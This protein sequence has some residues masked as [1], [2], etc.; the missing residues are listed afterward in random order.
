MERMFNPFKKPPILFNQDRRLLEPANELAMRIK[1]MGG[2]ALLVGGFVRD[3]LTGMVSKD[4]DMEVYGV[5]AD[6]L[7]RTLH[8]LY[9]EK[10]D[11]VGR[12]FGVLKVFLGDGLD[13]DVSIP[14]RESKTGSGHKGF[15][16]TGDPNMSVKEAAR[17]RD[18]TMNSL[19]AD[20][21]TGQIVDSFGGMD[22]IKNKILRVTD[23]ERFQDDPLRVYRAVQFAARLGFT[24]EP[25]SF[26]LM[27]EMV[28]RG[29]LD[30]LSPERVTEELKKLLLKSERPSVGFEYMRE[31]G[32]IERDYPELHSLIG[33]EQ[34]P[35]WHPEGDVWIHTMM[36]LDQAATI[37][38]DFSPEERLQITVGALVHDLGKP[39]TTKRMEKHGVMRITSLGHEEA[40]VEPAKQLLGRFI[41]GDEVE[42][43]AVAAARDHLKPGM[44]HRAWEKGELNDEQYANALRKWLKRSL[45]ISWRVLLAA[46]ESDY[47]GRTLPGVQTE[48][49][50]AGEHAARVILERGLDKEA[51][52]PLVQGRDL[53]A[54]GLK[55]GPIFRRLIDKI[56][57]ARDEGRIT[58]REEA[59]DLAKELISEMK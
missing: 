45:P 12:S 16:V 34:E 23:P 47:R 35:E 9:P 46:S 50:A 8:Q 15:A 22:D 3:S 25:K 32:I 2:Q 4:A 55:P 14:R 54:L 38:K 7:E 42:R 59:L 56:E 51:A 19:A 26:E 36:V 13:L 21:L 11:T 31:L 20:P 29:D 28:E 17:R 30:E 44:L 24:I 53:I 18:F 39:P 43:A 57:H 40:G 48:P 52:T 6:T 10:V 33:V 1:S 5:D 37:S 41:F 58:S 49:Y 27:R